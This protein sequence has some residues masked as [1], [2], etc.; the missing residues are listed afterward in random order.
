[1]TLSQLHTTLTEYLNRSRGKENR[2]R[3][4]LIEGNLISIQRRLAFLNEVGLGYLHLNRQVYTLSAGEAQRIKLASLLGSDLSSLTLLIDEPS[5]GMHPCEI[6]ALI[7]TLQELKDAGNT[8]VIVEHDP[9]IIQAA[10]HLVD[11]GPGAGDKG[12]EIVVCGQMD[13][14]R[15]SEGITAQW[16]RGEREINLPSHRRKPTEWIQL[17]GCRAHNLLIQKARIPLGTLTGVCGVSGSGKSSLIIDTL[18]RI[19]APVQH[20]TSVAYE[21]FQPGEYDQLI[22]APPR[23]LVV[24]QARTGITNP[25]SYLRIDRLLRKIYATSP[26]AQSMGLTER[27]FSRNCNACR[28]SGQQR[29]DMGFLP[30]VFSECEACHGTGYQAEIW[31]IKLEG[32]S[33]PE[34]EQRTLDEVHARFADQAPL[35]QILNAARQVGLGYLVLRQ[36]GRSLSGGEAQRLK[37]VRELSK[38]TQSQTLYLLD[39]PTVGQHMEDVDRL[40]ELLHRLVDMGHSVLLIEHHPHLLAVC[41]WLIELGPGGGPEG[42]RIIAVGTPEQLA[43]LDTPT[44]SF[45]REILGDDK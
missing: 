5:R 38:R 35:V 37:L 1:M 22:G 3:F 17:H 4:N 43:R 41:D 39:E 23:T 31:E 44:A 14:V 2:N 7:D 42:G 13:Q 26:I 9:M 24:D 19:L 34:L 8:I 15:S 40:A 29:I 28:G 10:D 16:L 25:G 12:G 36:P 27:D 11:L 32:L 45:L 21:P 6:E 20:T 30:A 33:L 18:G